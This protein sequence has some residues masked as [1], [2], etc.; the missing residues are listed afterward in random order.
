MRIDTAA[1]SSGTK[2]R[3]DANTNSRTSKA[4]AAPSSVS[5]KTLGPSVSPPADR[6]PYDVKPLS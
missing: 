4:P 6:S 1:M 5:T 2:A 3:N